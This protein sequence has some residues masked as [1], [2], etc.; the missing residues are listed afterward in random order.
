MEDYTR[1]YP[2]ADNE[3]IIS[4]FGNQMD[5]L[6]MSGDT[7]KYTTSL[8]DICWR[9]SGYQLL[10]PLWLPFREAEF[11]CKIRQ[12]KLALPT[13]K[14]ENT[15]IYDSF[16]RYKEICVNPNGAFYWLGLKSNLSDFQWSDLY[17]GSVVHWNNFNHKYRKPSREFSCAAVAGPNFPYEW[18]ASPCDMGMCPVCNFSSPPSVA[19][20]GLC[21]ESKFN[22]LYFLY[23]YENGVPKY[24]GWKRGQIIWDNSTWVIKDHFRKKLKAV[25]IKDE[26]LSHPLGKRTWE[27]TGDI[28]GSSQVCLQSFSLIFIFLSFHIFF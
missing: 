19:V 26:Q 6:R 8:E 7:R 16:I 14:E 13:N 21:K 27:V 9:H 3:A 1:C 15:F 12:G 24:E 28:C 2:R 18:H 25:M 20:R 22:R 11:V 23:G 5:G 17:S 4:T 10:V